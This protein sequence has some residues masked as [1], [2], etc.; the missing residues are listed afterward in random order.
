VLIAP[1]ASYDLNA[2]PV[3]V[4]TAVRV[5]SMNGD[6]AD[7]GSGAWN[8][9]ILRNIV[10]ALV[11]AMCVGFSAP[12]TA[13]A[14]PPAGEVIAFSGQC[15]VETA[16]QRRR[17]SNGDSVQAGDTLEV[18]EGSKLKLRMKD[19]SVISA[20]AGTRMTIDAYEADA[21]HR[22]GKLSLASGLLRTVVSAVTQP[23]RFEVETATGIAAVRS[24]DWFVEAR[25]DFT[26]VGV[27]EGTVI[28]TSIAT[29]RSVRI[30]ARWGARLQPG[31]NPVPPRVWNQVEFEDVISRTTIN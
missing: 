19:G 20:G 10:G 15:F 1:A 11:A 7:R 28:L 26:Q 9:V 30:P 8:R 2:A 3:P 29:Q 5:E 22:Y 14:A 16:G 27:L 25:S 17:L 4:R 21:Q 13:E 12:N 18:P 23:S 31:K 6:R 24:T